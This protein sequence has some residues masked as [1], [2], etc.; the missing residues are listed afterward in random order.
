MKANRSVLLTG[1]IVA[2]M[3]TAAMADPTD[4]TERAVCFYNGEYIRVEINNM[5]PYAMRCLVDCNVV[6]SSTVD[7]TARCSFDVPRQSTRHCSK[8]VP[9]AQGPEQGNIRELECHATD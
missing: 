1:A 9:Q 4:Q 6:I 8:R 7:K 2:A 3:S 5:S